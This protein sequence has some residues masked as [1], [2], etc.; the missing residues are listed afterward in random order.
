MKRLRIGTNITAFQRLLSAEQDDIWSALAGGTD[1]LMPAD[2]QG[3]NSEL[4][5][6]FL[7]SVDVVHQGL[8]AWAS[9]QGR[10]A[11]GGWLR[12]SDDPQEIKRS[13]SVFALWARSAP[14]PIPVT[15]V[16]GTA[17]IPNRHVAIVLKIHD[18]ASTFEGYA[19]PR[20]IGTQARR[21][22]RLHG[23]SLEV[24]GNR[25]FDIATL[26]RAYTSRFPDDDVSRR[27]I[28]LQLQRAPHLFF[29]VFDGIWRT[30][31]TDDVIGDEQP[32]DLVPFDR[33]PAFGD[34]DFEPESIGAFLYEALARDGPMRMVELRDL[35]ETQLPQRISRSSVGAVLQSNP[36]FVRLSPGVYRPATSH[37]RAIRRVSSNSISASKRA[38]LSLLC[39]VACDRGPN[40][41][42]SGLGPPP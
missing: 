4:P 17:G 5:P 19:C 6:E 31:G 41:P 1:L 40:H 22:C 12:G 10:P 32:L 21:T 2:L 29:R 39:Y 38:P 25:L 20:I 11:L 3:R 8:V 9:S 23:L 24:F 34:G 7:L 16:A 30:L 33:G 35:A 36:E 28:F 13:L 42:I 26:C 37:S 14:G 15:S 27:V 18:E